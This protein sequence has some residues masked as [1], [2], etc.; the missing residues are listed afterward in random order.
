MSGLLLAAAV[1]P[2]HA[3]TTGVVRGTVLD[4]LGQAV[5]GA[6]VVVNLQGG[7]GVGFETETTSDGQFTQAGLASGFY[8]VV[9][10]KGELGS[11][12]YRV[13]VREHRAVTINFLLERGRSLAPWLAAEGER[14]ALAAAFVAG[15]VAN[16]ADSFEEA[17][18][19]FGRALDLNPSCVECHFN[20]GVTYAENG[21]FTEA[22]GAFRRALEVKPE[23]ALAYYGLANIYAKQNRPDD[24]AAAR[25]QANRIALTALAAGDA[26]AADAV[27]RGVT[28]LDAGNVSDAR[29]R[30]EDALGRTPN[31]APA[32][33]W[34][35][36]TLSVLGETALAARELRQYLSLEPDGEHAE[37][38]KEHL[39]A[40]EQ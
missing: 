19:H 36:V 24:A 33:Y 35:G 30:F 29:R 17:V 10:D 1:L 28:F 12:V 9:A 7:A 11:E 13:R 14:E 4:D 31:F 25:G 8:T 3:Q 2:A 23:Y 37:A 40:L 21:R 5:D 34:L 18:A 16:R 32:H 6:R 39:R 15:V 20:L 22:E 38:A 27:S 26:Q